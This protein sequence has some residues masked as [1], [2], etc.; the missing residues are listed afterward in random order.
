VEVWGQS[1]SLGTSLEQFAFAVQRLS[2]MP[3][4][5]Q[6]GPFWEEVSL[7]VASA[8]GELERKEL[9]LLC[10]AYAMSA[11]ERLGGQL[12]SA[13]LCRAAAIAEEFSAQDLTMVVHGLARGLLPGSPSASAES[14]FGAGAPRAVKRLAWAARK[15]QLE[16]GRPQ[17]AALLLHAFALLRH[18]RDAHLYGRWFAL[19]CKT[20]PAWDA[21]SMALLCGA[22]A[23]VGR[24]AHA[25][26]TEAGWQ[27]VAAR[28]A[29]LLG[30][31]NGQD[32]A[33]MALALN[34]VFVQP[35]AV[36]EF[37]DRLEELLCSRPRVND[38]LAAREFAL[39]LHALA[40]HRRPSPAAEEP[41]AQESGSQTVPASRLPATAWPFEEYA[42][43]RVREFTA[44]DLGYV[45]L[46]SVR[47]QRGGAPLFELILRRLKS[48]SGKIGG[49]ELGKICAVGTEAAPV[50]GL[51]R[52]LELMRVIRR[53]C[54]RLTPELT[55]LEVSSV[56]SGYALVAAGAPD[57]GGRR[58]RIWQSRVQARA[59]LDGLCARAE[60]VSPDPEWLDRLHSQVR[61][62]AE[63][64]G[65]MATALAS[66]APPASAMQSQGC[67]L[68]P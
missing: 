59:A 35:A 8:A 18:G 11:P 67:E 1:V 66:E 34:R 62:I 43:R 27:A 21:H 15:V 64:E 63:A 16:E 48:L 49:S 4:G 44:K 46:G 2:R 30:G 33:S 29:A 31:A 47:L 7:F 37:Y 50:L 9:A 24:R 60:E 14:R 42:A 40:V 51:P 13:L 41:S 57:G 36:A 54:I 5:A 26:T 39:V 32:M 55:S 68:G 53:D 38:F 3:L 61:R 65:L 6:H 56:A 12:G 52:S 22:F 58:A 23:S 25:L 20:L 28:C 19:A 10:N 17:Q 45:L